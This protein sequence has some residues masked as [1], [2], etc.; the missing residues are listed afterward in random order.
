M[1]T[2]S[3]TYRPKEVYAHFLGKR[4]KGFGTDDMISISPISNDVWNEH[5]GVAGEITRS[6]NHEAEHYEV[7]FT[8]KHSSPSLWWL[9]SFRA[10]DKNGMIPDLVDISPLTIL[11]KGDRGGFACVTSWIKNEPD[12]EYGTDAP[13]FEYTMLAAHGKIFRQTRAKQRIERFLSEFGAS[14]PSEFIQTF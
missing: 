12:T 1:G 8:L 5:I 9:E 14:N 10:A 3:K 13:E 11:E 7:S 6:Q 2:L 4:I